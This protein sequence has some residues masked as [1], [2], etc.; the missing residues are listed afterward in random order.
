MLGE[1]FAEEPNIIADFPGTWGGDNIFNNYF[2]VKLFYLFLDVN[3]SFYYLFI[4]K[5]CWCLP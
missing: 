4:Q 1:S 3:P 5:S 2:S